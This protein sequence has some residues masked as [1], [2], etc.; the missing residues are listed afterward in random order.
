MADERSLLETRV[1]L[2]RES[3]RAEA[4]RSVL[5]TRPV[6]ALFCLD[7]LSRLHGRTR[8]VGMMRAR[9]ARAEDE[10]DHASHQ[11]HDPPPQIDVDGL[12]LLVH[13]GV[14]VRRETVAADD[15]PNRGE[16]STD[17]KSEIERSG[18][19]HEGKG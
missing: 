18:T 12:G 2:M 15:E 19:R 8:S 7:S 6:L 4:L 9:C 11:H 10:H 13:R 5:E 16:Q 14:A 17:G 3:S 1:R